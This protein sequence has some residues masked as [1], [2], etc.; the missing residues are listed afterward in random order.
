MN[1][2][3]MLL[4]VVALRKKIASSIMRLPPKM[5]KSQ[6]WFHFNSGSYCFLWKGNAEEYFLVTELA[7][8]K[9]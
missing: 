1:I 7:E 2:V 3:N 6:D 4:Y 5:R 9:P 8:H